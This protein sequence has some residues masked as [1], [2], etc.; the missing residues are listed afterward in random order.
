MLALAGAAVAAIH[1]HAS[2]R[3]TKVTVTEREYHIALSTKKFSAGTYTF[4]VHNAGK[5]AHQLDLSGAGIKGTAHVPTI[6]PGK[7][8]AIT[9]KLTGG[10]LSLWC[11][12]PGHAS[13]G[14][15][16][17]VKLTGATSSGGATGGTTTTTGTPAGAA[18]G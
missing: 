1:G 13:L 12:L 16:A 6:N 8:R 14:M 11:P 9:V 2:A 10:T 7:T 18:W 4:S 17:S 5:I 15:K 3:G